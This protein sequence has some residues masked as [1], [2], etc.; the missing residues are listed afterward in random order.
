[1]GSRST[2]EGRREVR[3]GEAVEL[4][5]RR[6]AATQ[7]GSVEVSRRPGMGW[8][9]AVEVGEGWRGVGVAR[10]ASEAA[11]QELGRGGNGGG[12]KWRKGGRRRGVGEREEEEERENGREGLDARGARSM[13]VRRG[14]TPAATRR[15]RSTCAGP[16][17][18]WVPPVSDSKKGQFQ[19]CFLPFC[20]LTI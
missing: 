10:K 14:H 1:M 13:A 17:D 6:T 8:T 5:L 19:M 7:C 18:R 16:A 15:P 12:Q 11:A 4:E 9:G 2:V 3:D 20:N